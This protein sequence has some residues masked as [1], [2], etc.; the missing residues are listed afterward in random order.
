MLQRQNDA[1]SL[2]VLMVCA[3]FPPYIGGTE[4]HVSE[5]S[6]RLAAR[7]HEV[8]VVT[9]VLDPTEANEQVERGVV[10]RRVRAYPRRADL[11]IAPKLHGLIRD[12]DADIVHV[13]G[14]HT[15]VAPLAMNA[16]GRAGLPYVVTFHSGGHSSRLRR[17]LRPTHHRLLAPLV[18]RAQ[19]VIG[20][21]EFE[22]DFFVRRMSLD[23]GRALTITNGVSEEFKSVERS[24]STK[25]GLIAAIGRLEHYK[26]HHRVIAALPE[27]RRR[28]PGAR[29]RVIG[30]GPYE[31]AL[32]ALADQLGVGG[33]V[34]FTKVPYG[35]R[36]LLAERMAEADVIAILSSYESQG[37]AGLEAVAT[38]ARL[39]VADGS[40]LSELRRFDGVCVV[41]RS[42]TGHVVDA[43]V[44]QLRL[45]RQQQRPDVPTWDDTATHVEAVY[46]DVLA[47]RAGMDRS[48]AEVECAS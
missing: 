15:V 25:T 39:V 46:A 38:G 29:L 12:T 35:D 30:D 19:R 26:G 11:H 5:L 8:T 9:T 33:A 3:R 13:Q 47:D 1:R 37:I 36:P 48:A 21:S 41:P 2:R 17:A 43:L 32:R 28:V 40:A 18:Q 10:V 44:R 31:G 34:E 45:P 23:P 27:V 42:D 24:V 7:G 22:R 20:V 16:A 14:Y 4:A 6:T